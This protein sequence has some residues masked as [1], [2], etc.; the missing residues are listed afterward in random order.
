MAI[1]YDTYA[2]THRIE[3]IH[4]LVKVENQI[5]K[6]IPRQRPRNPIEEKLLLQLDITRRDRLIRNGDWI[7]LAPHKWRVKVF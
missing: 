5:T 3:F 7:E 6:R 1:N 2:E 4:K